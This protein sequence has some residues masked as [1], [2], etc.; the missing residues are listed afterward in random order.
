MDSTS[1]TANPDKFYFHTVDYCV[2]A[3]MLVFSAT[4]GGYFGF[5]KYVQTFSFLFKCSKIVKIVKICLNYRKTPNDENENVETA[6]NG[7]TKKPIQFGSYSMREYLLGS[8]KLKPFPVAMSLV[9]RYFIIIYV[10][11]H[12]IESTQMIKLL[13]MFCSILVIFR[14]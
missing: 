5:I 2:F 11:I 4:S 7:A 3:A 13:K 1:T 10:Y 9:A 14:V 8:R 12:S 6:V